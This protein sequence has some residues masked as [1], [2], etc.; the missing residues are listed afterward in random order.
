M[1]EDVVDDLETQ[2]RRILEF[3]GLPFE[4]A[5][6]NFHETERS[7]QDPQFRTG[8]ATHLPHRSGT[9]AQ[10]RT[11]GWTPSRKLWGL[12]LYG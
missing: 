9:M 4:E 12:K 3:C 6:L 2:V 8:Q 1:H 11:P 10:L 7:V 5:C